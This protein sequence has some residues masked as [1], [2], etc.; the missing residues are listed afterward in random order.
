MK[1]SETQKELPVVKTKRPFSCSFCGI[2]HE[3][4][5]VII[6]GPMV[7]ICDECVDLCTQIVYE[8]RAAPLKHLREAP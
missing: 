8:W 6:A 5:K 4:A 1:E 7:N 3:E 2:T